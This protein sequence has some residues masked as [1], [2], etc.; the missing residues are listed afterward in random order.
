MAYTGGVATVG[1]SG[2]YANYYDLAE[3]L[4]NSNG[5][6]TS[7]YIHQISD[8]H[9]IGE[10]A[11]FRGQF[12]NHDFIIDGHGYK[13]SAETVE[14][15]IHF[16]YAS[17]ISNVILRNIV[18]DHINPTNSGYYADLGM[19][20]EGAFTIEDTKFLGSGTYTNGLCIYN[21]GTT[22][23]TTIRNCYFY[24][25]FE[26]SAGQLIDTPYNHADNLFISNVVAYCKQP[27]VSRFMGGAFSGSGVN[28]ALF[29]FSSSCW[30]DPVLPP[31]YSGSLPSGMSPT[32]IS[33]YR[34]IV[35]SDYTGDIP[36]VNPTGQYTTYDP[37][38]S[39]MLHPVQG[40]IVDRSGTLPFTTTDMV[41]ETWISPYTIG[42]LQ[43]NTPPVSSGTSINVDQGQTVTTVSGGYSTVLWNDY[44]VDNN[45]LTAYVVSGVNYGT[46][47]FTSSGTFDY[48][49]DG[50]DNFID[51]FQ[52][53]AFDGQ[54]SGN[55][56]NVNIYINRS[57]NP[58]VVITSPASGYRTNTT[59]TPI[60]WTVN[61]VPQ[62]SGLTEDLTEGSNVV[63]RG[64]TDEFGHVGS[65]Y[66]EIILDTV[67]PSVIITSPTSGTYTNTTPIAVAW[68]VDSVPQ[69]SGLSEA[70]SEGSNI[71]TRSATDDVGNSGSYSI[72]V[73]LDTISPVVKI[74]SP[75]SGTYTATTPIAVSW[76]VDSV[77][78]TSGL[79]QSLTEGSNVITR[80]Y[81]DLA[82]NSGSD[83]VEV[84]LDTQAPVVVITSPADGSSFG[85]QPIPVSWT[86]DGVPQTSGTIAYL[87]VGSNV[88]TREYTDQA[89]HYGSDSVTVTYDP[90]LIYYP[91]QPTR[92]QYIKP[93]TSKSS[94]SKEE[95]QRNRQSLFKINRF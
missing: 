48:T 36:F 63:V 71:I 87:T 79:S 86:V 13:I 56:A 82:G 75:I 16:R 95:R 83:A 1:I 80:V 10:R 66:T 57:P 65:G 88:I 68:T 58:V 24:W 74:T 50:T 32:D 81:T 11:H 72:E 19:N 55:I 85:T 23:S 61:G 3:D 35:T 42:P 69:T 77:P 18:F 29:G 67:P 4:F 41:G 6:V 60:A 40:T 25:D 22:T 26:T 51:A 59:P 90:S 34:N 52:Y 84:I 64:Y 47:N 31:E 9:W 54:A 93:S 2:D 38:S 91:P 28:I 20:N 14:Q 33:W 62:T 5:L 45:T 73:I 8:V 12:R 46:L 30:V 92:K 43:Y 76:T 15:V 94:L 21:D 49:H 78:Q 53:R 89:G 37:Y 17:E 44:D 70:L 7:G 39:D 27:S